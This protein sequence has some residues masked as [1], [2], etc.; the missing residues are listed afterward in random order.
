[1]HTLLSP[2]LTPYEKYI[3]IHQ[4]N[5]SNQ[6]NKKEQK[7]HLDSKHNIENTVTY[8]PT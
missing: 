8:T 3:F 4:R 5:D 1:M 2:L 7:N 6:T